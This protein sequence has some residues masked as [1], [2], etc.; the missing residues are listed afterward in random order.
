MY[1]K[2]WYTC[3]VV[4]SPIQTCCFFLPFSLPSP[5]SLLSPILSIWRGYQIDYYSIDNRIVLDSLSLQGHSSF[6]RWPS[7]YC[8][9]DKSL[10]NEICR[11]KSDSLWTGERFRATIRRVFK[12]KKRNKMNGKWHPIGCTV[13]NVYLIRKAQKWNYLFIEALAASLISQRS[14][15][16]AMPILRR[17]VR[18]VNIKSPQMSP[19]PFRL[20]TYHNN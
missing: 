20:S 14:K 19:T 9:V 6:C 3:K 5:S 10:V 17:K 18:N 1:K 15:Q 8:F 12:D 4:V 2:A 11:W 16:L 13:G 7:T